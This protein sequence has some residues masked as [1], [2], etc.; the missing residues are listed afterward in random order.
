MINMGI[1]ILDFP[2]IMFK[3]LVRAKVISIILPEA[4]ALPHQAHSSY[5]PS[6]RGESEAESLISDSV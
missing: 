4:L 3:L 5:S 1:L 2:S 6:L